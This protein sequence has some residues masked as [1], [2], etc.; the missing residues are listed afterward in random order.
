MCLPLSLSLSLPKSFLHFECFTFS[1]SHSP[2]SPRL[3]LLTTSVCPALFAAGDEQLRAGALANGSL[4]HRARRLR[5]A[6]AALRRPRRRRDPPAPP[7]RRASVK[8]RRRRRRRRRKGARPAGGA[9]VGGAALEPRRS[10]GGGAARRHRHDALPRR[11]GRC[12]GRRLRRY[13]TTGAAAVYVS[14]LPPL[15]PPSFS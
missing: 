4:G 7:L 9:A 1:P 11:F 8:R 5:P 6:P 15:F 10:G 3:S 2:S 12:K 13:T 14:L